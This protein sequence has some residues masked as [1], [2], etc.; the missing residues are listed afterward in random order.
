MPPVATTVCQAF[1][2][3][4][5][6]NGDGTFDAYMTADLS[7]PAT[8]AEYEAVQ[9]FAFLMAVVWVAGLPL[10][11]AVLLFSRR[12]EIEARK[13]RRG[14]ASLATLSFCFR[15]EYDLT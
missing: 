7:I 2:T 10:G 12:R 15:Y 3:T 4:N 9:V 11:L 6:D 1:S 5:F 14:A 8:G 13:T